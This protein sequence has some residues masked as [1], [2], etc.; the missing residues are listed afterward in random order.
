MRFPFWGPILS[1]FLIGTSH[2]PFPPWAIFFCFIPLWLFAL[3]HD[4]LKPL[5]IGGFLC[6]CV[7]T[8]IGFN[9]I[10][11]TIKEIG[12]SFWPQ[13]FIFILAFIVFANLHISLSLCLWFISKQKLKNIKC[14]F[15]RSLCICCSLPVYLGLCTQYYPM[16]FKWHFGYTWFYARWPAA[17][18]AEIWGF[19]FINTLILFSNLLFLFVFKSTLFQRIKFF[20]RVSVSNS[21]SNVPTISIRSGAIILC[22]WLVT[23]MSLQFWGG[24]LKN[25]LPEPD[26]KARVLVVQPNIENKM[27]EDKTW[28][29]FIVS[30]ILTE[31]KK[32]LPIKSD[33]PVDFILWPEGAY[34]YGINLLQVEQGKD[35]IQ[36][37]ISN[38]NI[39]LVV[40]AKGEK[41]GEYTNSLFVFDQKAQLVRS[42]YDKIVLIPIGEYTPGE[43]W[44]PF[45]NKFF[46]DDQRSFI[47]GTGDNKV[48]QLNG[49]N[50]GLQICY[51]GLFDWLTRDVVREGA[52]ILVN[53]SNDA[54]F[55]TWQ[56]PWQHLYVTLSRAV[57]VRR[58]L[59]RGT[60]SGFSA[61]VSAKGEISSSMVFGNFS[62]IK[63]VSFYSRGREPSSLFTSWGYYINQVFL[64]I[65]L[66]LI[67]V[68]FFCA[69]LRQ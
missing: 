41:V 43:K 19:E 31:T 45:I 39:P 42:S 11:Y 4:R 21:H 54:W 18:T 63:E 10:A 26:Q 37:S 57:E 44:V 14:S 59:V 48:I 61:V 24:Y 36:K 13:G 55:G 27:Q 34:P 17:Q 68:R 3:N 52:S 9:W 30:K 1:G 60:N 69:K 8:V 56:E 65:F 50:L 40:S 15:I 38:F 6:Q 23:F 33:L 53:V 28:N 46:F 22:V 62:E 32:Y 12:I 29:D 2:I 16:I 5:L 66:I 7:A 20:K 67:Y 64:W 49:L 35:P 25:R 47:K 58:P 51:E